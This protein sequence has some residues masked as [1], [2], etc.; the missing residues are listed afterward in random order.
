MTI[1]D[2]LPP[3]QLSAHELLAGYAQGIFPMANSATDEQLLWFQPDP[4]GIMPLGHLHASR[5]LIKDLRR[6]NWT[7]QHASDFDQIVRLCAARDETWINHSLKQLYRQLFDMGHAHALEIR[8][9]GQLAGGI[10][11][12]ILGRA[13]FGE[14]MFSTQR[15]GSRMALLWMDAQ[16]RRSGFRLFDTQYLTPHLARMG[17]IEVP[18]LRY[19]QMLH[20]ALAEESDLMRLPIPSRQALL[21]EITHTS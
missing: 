11:G 7:A 8:L 21:Q 12:V 3:S 2:N 10:F 14:S 19:R 16:L 17:G 13:Y 1:P 15:N 20:Q 18:R 6:G 4:R 5:S 9:D